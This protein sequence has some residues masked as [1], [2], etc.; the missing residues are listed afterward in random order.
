MKFKIGERV[1]VFDPKDRLSSPLNKERGTVI[2]YRVGSTA[3]AVQFD[4]FIG[5]HD[6]DRMGRYGYCS[7]MLEASLRR[8]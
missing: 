8:L 1:M 7:Y 2:G 3:V 5:G 4:N 6:C